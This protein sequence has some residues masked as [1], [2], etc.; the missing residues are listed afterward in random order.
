MNFHFVNIKYVNVSANDIY[1]AYMKKWNA[2][3][4]LIY[5]FGIIAN[6]L[7]CFLLKTSHEIMTSTIVLYVYSFPYTVGHENR[8]FKNDYVKSI[9]YTVGFLLIIAIAR[10]II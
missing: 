1:I 2:K 6:T 10:F 9:V 8:F 5:F 7:M 3:L 4:Y